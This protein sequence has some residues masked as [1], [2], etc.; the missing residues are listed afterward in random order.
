[1]TGLTLDH[2]AIA[3]GTLEEGVE[4]VEMQL[5]VRMKPGGRHAHYGTHNALLGLEDALY[6]EVI[7]IDALAEPAVRPRWF[8]LDRL[9]G[10][11]RV[12]IWACQSEDLPRTLDRHPKA[13][14]AVP[15]ERGD[16]KWR[17]AVPPSGILPYDNCFPALM[18]WDVDDHPARR[19]MS[20]G[21]RLT[22]LTVRHPEAK[23]LQRELAAD[24][25]D[26][27]VVFEGG[28]PGLSLHFDTPAGPRTL[29]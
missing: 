17:M 2:F 18:Q 3:A 10:G 4:W 7:S 15:L 21:C 5:G 13:G 27:R 28:G 16:L 1:M 14:E 20:S 26:P 12:Q 22:R 25:T 23:A 19:L 24:F 8:D 9:S 6:L 29:A 11:P